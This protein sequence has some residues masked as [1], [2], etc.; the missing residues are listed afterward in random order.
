MQSLLGHWAR[1]FFIFWFTAFLYKVS[2]QG[3][4]KIKYPKNDESVKI[5]PDK[6]FFFISR[7]IPF[8][9]YQKSPHGIYFWT[10]GKHVL[11]FG[12]GSQHLKPKNIFFQE[13]SF[14]PCLH[15]HNGKSLVKIIFG[16]KMFICQ[17]ISQI[18]VALF[19]NFWDAKRSHFAGCVSEQC[20]MQKCIQSPHM[21]GYVLLLLTIE[22]L[23]KETKTIYL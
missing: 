10:S 23:K 20:G 17:P 12:V 13:N 2:I 7:N 4:I 19:K 8:F 6:S 15:L 11:L 14:F 22:C 18:F 9:V 1:L 16:R 5:N 3:D 21:I